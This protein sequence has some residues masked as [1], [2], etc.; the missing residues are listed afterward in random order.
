MPTDSEH[1][2]IDQPEQLGEVAAAMAAAPWVALDT[3][4]NSMFVYRERICLVQ[5]NAGGRLFVLDPLALP[6]RPETW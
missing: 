3:E 6:Y 4:S 1:Q 5:I 2:W